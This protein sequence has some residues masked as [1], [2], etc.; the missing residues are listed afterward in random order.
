MHSKGLECS[1][2]GG[3]GIHIH[4]YTYYVYTHT[5]AVKDQDYGTLLHDA[6]KLDLFFK[7]YFLPILNVSHGYPITVF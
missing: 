7:A 4:I 2:A 3:G 1:R 5:A 6:S